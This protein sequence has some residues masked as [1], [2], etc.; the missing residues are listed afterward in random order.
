MLLYT[1]IIILSL[2]LYENVNEFQNLYYNTNA[3]IHISRNRQSRFSVVVVKKL[4][5][6][7]HGLMVK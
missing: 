4:F 6:T 2:L 3:L 1:A 7:Q 5:D